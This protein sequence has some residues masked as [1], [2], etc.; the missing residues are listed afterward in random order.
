MNNELD[1]LK[2]QYLEAA[3]LCLWYQASKFSFHQGKASKE[4]E[5]RYR[6]LSHRFYREFLEK[7]GSA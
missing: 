3:R 5:I 4:L 1:N 6:D 2:N 7:K